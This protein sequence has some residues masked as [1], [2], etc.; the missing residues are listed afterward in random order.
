M[1]I[2]HEN[3]QLPFALDNRRYDPFSTM[4]KDL[5]QREFDLLFDFA[6]SLQD[7]LCERYSHL[8]GPGPELSCDYQPQLPGEGDHD[9]PW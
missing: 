3:H 1:D 2:G 4:P 6:C 5:S 8:L 9:I 7:W